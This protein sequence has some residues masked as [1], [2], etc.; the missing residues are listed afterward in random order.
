MT[1][2]KP[3]KGATKSQ[4]EKYEQHRAKMRE[5]VR[6]ASDAGRDIAPIP[7]C[8]NPERKAQAK[9]S[10]KFFCEEYFPQ[11]FSIQWSEDHLKV[12]AKIERAVKEGGLFAIAM[13]RGSGKT[14][15]CEVACVWAAVYGFHQFIL[16]IG[17]ESDSA[18]SVFNSIKSELQANELLLED[19]PEVCYPIEQLE[20]STNRAAGQHVS[21]KRTFIKWNNDVMV[22]PTVEGSPASGCVIKYAGITGRIRGM[23]HKREVDGKNARPTLCIIDDP[24]TD[25]SAR[26]PKQTADRLKVV[27]KT[28]LNLPGA[29]QTLSA[30]CPCTVIER[31][32]MADKLLTRKE[33]PEWQGER[34]KALYEFPKNMELWSE[35]SD[36]RNKDLEEDGD[37]SVATKFYEAHRKEMD[38]GAVVAWPERFTKKEVSGLQFLMNKYFEDEPAFLSEFQQEPVAEALSADQLTDG[39][40]FDKMNGRPRGEVPQYASKLTAYFDVQKNVL[41]YAVTAWSDD[42]TGAIIDYGAFP[43][44]TKRLFDLS[45][46]SPTLEQVFTGM[47]LEARLRRGLEYVTEE[48]LNREYEREDGVQMRIAKAYIDANWGNSTD[49][50]YNF[51]RES[52]F[53]SILAPSHGKYFGAREKPIAFKKRQQGELIG[54]NWYYPNSVK[55][56]AI[57]HII[58]DT[59]YWKSFV[60]NRLM[61]KAGDSGSLS[62]FGSDKREHQLL[63]DHFTAEFFTPTSG[64][65]RVVNEW[66]LR[67]GRKENHWFDCVVGA[68]VAA[69]ELGCTRPEFFQDKRYAQTTKNFFALAT[70]KT[71]QFDNREP[72]PSL[73]S[74]ESQ[75]FSFAAK[76]RKS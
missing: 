12:I 32:D 17:C 35:Y 63:V 30:I 21:G 31:E 70:G 22:L 56:R 50:V 38:E 53:S 61:T 45:T 71:K 69:N 74:G 34:L 37:G 72:D 68:S 51:C 6:Q 39:H 52:K 49:V 60:Y 24:Q 20:G 44:Q 40:I 3:G 15:L 28:I 62:L 73:P 48:V 23:K 8:V 11:L 54:H 66:Q 57:R 55:S 67:P 36:I 9:E 41:F 27:V 75:S 59:N 46:L 33:Y 4:K 65:E 47:G 64:N 26:S 7:M 14:T 10:F 58:I 5:R 13:P 16:I 25:E 2:V 19:F 1:I 18:A 29:G 43:K 42:F 76:A